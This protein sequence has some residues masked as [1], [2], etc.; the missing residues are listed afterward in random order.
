[1]KE[2][3]IKVTNTKKRNKKSKKYKTSAS[4]SKSGLFVE[5]ARSSQKSTKR[6]NLILKIIITLVIIG[7]VV[8]FVLFAKNYLIPYFQSEFTPDR[9]ETSSALNSEEENYT[10]TPHYDSLG[11]EILDNELTLFVINER[12]PDEEYSPSTARIN[13]VKLEKK[14]IDAVRLLINDAKKDGF[15]LDFT[16]GYTSFKEQERL[17]EEKV[18]ALMQDEN[19]TL[20]MARETAKEYVPPAGTS[21]FQTGM[22]I[23]IDGDSETFKESQTYE[24][25]YKNMAKYGFVFRYPEDKEKKTG[26]KADYTVIRYVGAENAE[27]MRQLSMCL[28]EYVNYVENQ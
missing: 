22:C 20:V 18:E 17:F 28:E 1:M 16:Q 21:D 10:P 23:R 6:I 2:K 4:S 7:V 14:I 9:E 25:L 12:Y 11:L 3:K 15:V 19:M 8:V 24:W 27:K 13:G 5:N 26:M